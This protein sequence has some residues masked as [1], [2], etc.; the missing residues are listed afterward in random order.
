MKRQMK[1]TNFCRCLALPRI[2]MGIKP[3]QRWRWEQHGR[4]NLYGISITFGLCMWL[5]VGHL[6]IC[7]FIGFERNEEGEGEEGKRRRSTSTKVFFAFPNFIFR[8]FFLLLLLLRLTRIR[9]KGWRIYC[10]PE[11]LELEMANQQQ[12]N[13][14]RQ[15]EKYT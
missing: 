8:F 4:T 10:C 7:F 11:D 15:D 2:V 13:D 1:R 9:F 12:R 6:E 3:S 5:A 14:W